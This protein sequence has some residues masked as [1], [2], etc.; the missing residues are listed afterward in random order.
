MFWW[1]VESLCC[2]TFLH[3]NVKSNGWIHWVVP[4]FSEQSFYGKAQLRL[5]FPWQLPVGMWVGRPD[6]FGLEKGSC[7]AAGAAVAQTRCGD[8]PLTTSLQ[9]ESQWAEYVNNNKNSYTWKQWQ[10]TSSSM[11]RLLPVVV[12]TALAWMLSTASHELNN[13]KSLVEKVL[14]GNLKHKPPRTII[15]TLKPI[16]GP[17]AKS[18][19]WSLPQHMHTHTYINTAQH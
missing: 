10:G 4:Y 13:R 19:Y 11:G 9:L 18:C 17:Q 5:L 8:E 7:G 14:Q 2:K 12:I 3:L 15:K 16:N 1:S 6:P